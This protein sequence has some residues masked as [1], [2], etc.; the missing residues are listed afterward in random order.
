M[1]FVAKAPWNGVRGPWQREWVGG[2]LGVRVHRV[3][4][5]ADGAGLGGAHRATLRRFA[6]VPGSAAALSAWPPALAPGSGSGL[7]LCSVAGRCGSGS[8]KIWCGRSSTPCFP[9]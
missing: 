5:P 1:F 2:A 4:G 3:S 6:G 9:I 7:A 8:L